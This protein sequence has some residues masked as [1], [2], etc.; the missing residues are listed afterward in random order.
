MSRT[1][2]SPRAFGVLRGSFVLVVTSLLL[3]S[4][5]VISSTVSASAVTENLAGP[6]AMSSD[7]Y[8]KAVHRR[9]NVVRKAHD[10]PRLRIQK[11]TDRVA[12]RWNNH[13]AT[14][15]LFYHQSMRKI[16]YRCDARYAG[17]T[18]GRGAITPRVLVRMWMQ[19][20][21]HRAVLMSP[22]ARRIGVAAQQDA[23]GRWV[24]TAN[25]MRF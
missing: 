10:L 4:G 3:T 15:D 8:E 9:V 7:A 5:L 14:K 24:T 11:C 23:F 20:E 19:S 25:F 1:V 6:V 22:H 16:L 12:E 2:T 18:L 13:L 21:G 17:E